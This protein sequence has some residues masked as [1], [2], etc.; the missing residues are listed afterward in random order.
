M[1]K[2]I[3][4]FEMVDGTRNSRQIL[5]QNQLYNKHLGITWRCIQEKCFSTLSANMETLTI[6]KDPDD[7]TGHGDVLGVRLAVMRA[8]K[9]MKDEARDE[10]DI[11]IKT[12]YDRNRKKCLEEGRALVEGEPP[13]WL[14]GDMVSCN[15]GC[16][17]RE[18]TKNHCDG[19][20]SSAPK[21]FFHFYVIFGQKNVMIL[22]C[23][24][25]CLPDKTA[26]I[27]TLK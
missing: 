10:P 26:D 24:Y 7:H 25:A 18:S 27:A 17:L 16:L 23:V 20:F 12:I 22:P 5:Y 11:T 2:M 4:T 21:H 13:L 14:I 15:G 19:T 6:T 1:S 3:K 9:R 8:L